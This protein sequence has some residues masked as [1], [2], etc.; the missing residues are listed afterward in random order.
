MDDKG[1]RETGRRLRG[2]EKGGRQ[3]GSKCTSVLGM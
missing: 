2:F 3:V 1:I